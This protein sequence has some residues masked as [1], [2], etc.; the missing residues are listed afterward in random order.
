[1]SGVRINDDQVRF[2]QEEGYLVVK[3]ILSAEEVALLRGAAVADKKL[4]EHSFS[5]GDGEGGAA[6]LALFQASPSSIILRVW[7]WR[8]QRGQE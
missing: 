5:V 7:C 1:M 6:R 8:D 2:F 4:D 3:E